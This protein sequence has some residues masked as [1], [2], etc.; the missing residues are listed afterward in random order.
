MK[1]LMFLMFL[2]SMLCASCES[3]HRDMIYS[4]KDIYTYSFDIVIIDSC[5]YLLNRDMLAHKG[6]CRFCKERNKNRV[7][8]QIGCS[9]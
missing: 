8:E 4:K 5:E 9:K 2:A 7:G 6:N 1:K 3:K